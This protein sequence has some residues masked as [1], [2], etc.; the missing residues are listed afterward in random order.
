MR[1]LIATLFAA[2]CLITAF[3]Q[4][5]S[6]K[7]AS[8]IGQAS[9]NQKVGQGFQI[10][11][12]GSSDDTCQINTKLQIVPNA[13]LGKL[14]YSDANGFGTWSRD[15]L[16][17]ANDIRIASSDG[18][19]IGINDS[20]GVRS[21][22]MW[23]KDD[24][25]K[26]AMEVNQFGAFVTHEH[27]SQPGHYD[28]LL[29]IVHYENSLNRAPGDGR[30]LAISNTNDINV[31]SITD[32]ATGNEI[33]KF[34][35]TDSVAKVLVNYNAE[36]QFK[37][38]AVLGV[39]SDSQKWRIDS[40][41][42]A[43]LEGIS[44]TDGTQG[45]GK[46]LTSDANGNATWQTYGYGEMGFGDSA[47]TVNLTINT[48]TKATN[49]TNNLWLNGARDTLDVQYSGDSLIVLKDGTYTINGYV[50]MEGAN[51]AIL[52]TKIYLNGALLCDCNAYNTLS[53]NRRI[54]IPF[55]DIK[56][57][58]A[59]DVLEVYVENIADNTDVVMV[60]GKILVT[61]IRQ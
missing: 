11:F 44:I 41:G 37:S 47:V 42:V 24:T 18:L 2:I 21:A 38:D 9:R 49:A 1:K 6:L 43:Y 25:A 54:S 14:L 51:G 15:I 29:S 59:G 40:N 4:V 50:C 58:S 32:T 46:V 33:S 35:N 27:Q 12:V 55:T 31:M 8:L 17:G 39:Y 34:E 61:Q 60:S 56:T 19:T 26:Y 57:L 3:G 13:G 30:I 16:I 53:A 20:V 23:Y 10:G 22:F 45:T 28:G 36:V 5:D 52:T 7:N 48:P